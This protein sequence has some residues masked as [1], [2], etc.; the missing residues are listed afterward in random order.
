MA[1]LR[2]RRALGWHLGGCQNYD[3]SLGTLNIRCRILIGIQKG[4]II[5]TTTH[6]VKA[7]HPQDFSHIG[8]ARVSKSLL[9]SNASPILLACEGTLECWA[10]FCACAGKCIH[11]GDARK[12]WVVLLRL[13]I[14]DAIIFHA[15]FFR[16]SNLYPCARQRHTKA[17]IRSRGAVLSLDHLLG[18]MEAAWHG[19]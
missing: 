6:V 14:M 13:L 4:T 8:P 5:L 16:R 1:L 7:E 11:H 10:F 2:G 18:S 3:P 17:R 15:A 19:L 12:P 9:V